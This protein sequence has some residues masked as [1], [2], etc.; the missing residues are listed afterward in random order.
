MTQREAVYEACKGKCV[1]CGRVQRRRTDLWGWNAH[2]VI[3]QQTL[4]RRKVPSRYIR[5]PSLCVVLC[6]RCHGAQTSAMGRV[7]LDLI[8]QAV[9]DAVAELGDWAVDLLRREHPPMEQAG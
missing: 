4:K 9:Q 8:P 2:H 1:G 7:P 6:F 5:G 3:K